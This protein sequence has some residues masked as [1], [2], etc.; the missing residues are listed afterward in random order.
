MNIHWRIALACAGIISMSVAQAAETLRLEDAVTR[1]LASNPSINA[2]AAQ[3]DAV[4]A[5]AKL[6][7]LPTPFVIGADVDNVVGTGT[8]RGFQSAETTLRISR[9]LELGGKQAAREAVGV[10]EVNLQ[11]HQ[12]GIARLDLKRLTSSRFVQALALQQR[13]AYSEER[14]KQAEQTRKEVASWV[15]AARN[16]ESDLQSA[17]IALDEA[18][19]ARETT[20]SALVAA[21][22]ALAAIWGDSSPSFDQLIGDLKF[23]PSIEPFDALAERLPRTPEL[24]ASRLQADTLAA[25]RRAAESLAKPDLDVGVGVKRLEDVNDHALVFSVSMPLG[26]GQRSRYSV[27]QAD[28]ELAAV[29]ARKESARFE[30]Y[31]TLFTIYQELIQTQREVEVLRTSMLP[32]AE[33]ALSTTRKGFDA[34]RFSFL[35]LTQAQQTLFDLNERAVEAAA[36]YHLLMI[37]VKRLTAT[38]E[39]M[40]L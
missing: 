25:R 28:A 35:S 32:N 30:R 2:E 8:M 23:L 21:R 3:L 40:T 12:A 17:E 18:R 14:V 6:E 29:E 16:P 1:A 24:W 4:R 5:R 19:L 26:G 22:L 38:V 13:L 34:G 37:E 33:K 10:A 39:D 11:Q 20:A 27:A 31:Q 15:R 7:S 9:V 36:R